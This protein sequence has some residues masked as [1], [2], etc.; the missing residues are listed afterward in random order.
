[1]QFFLKLVQFLTVVAVLGSNGQY[2]WTPNGYAAGIVA[3]LAALLVT[4]TITGSLA[5]LRSL[6]RAKVRTRVWLLRSLKHLRDEKIPSLRIMGHGPRH[7]LIGEIGLN[8]GRHDGTPGGGLRQA[9]QSR[10]ENMKGIHPLRR[11]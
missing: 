7:Q 6:N 2:H 11:S 8:R 5:I 3:V 1:M 10:I 9:K 4:V